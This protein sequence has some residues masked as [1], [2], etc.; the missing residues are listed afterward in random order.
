MY[1]VYDF[2]TTGTSPA[3][4]GF[5]DFVLGRMHAAIESNKIDIGLVGTAGAAAAIVL[6]ERFSTHHVRSGNGSAIHVRHSFL[7][8]PKQVKSPAESRNA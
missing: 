5:T 2:E 8:F 1:A 3:L 4:Y 7:P 6:G